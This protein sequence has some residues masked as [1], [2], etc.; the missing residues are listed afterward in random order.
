MA[1]APP[2]L[3]STLFDDPAQWDNANPSYATLCTTYGHSAT[4]AT[5]PNARAGLAALATRAPVVLAFVTNAE[6]DYVY[7]GHSLTVL[8]VRH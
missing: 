4:A 8:L 1:A 7:V 3:F 2:P 5:A 6:P